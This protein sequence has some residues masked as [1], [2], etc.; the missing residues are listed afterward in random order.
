MHASKSEGG[1]SNV[2]MRLTRALLQSRCT[3]LLLTLLFFLLASPYFQQTERQPLHVVLLTIVCLGGVRALSENRKQVIV[4]L[5]MAAPFVIGATLGLVT[6][7]GAYGPTLFVIPF[8][9]YVTY[10]VLKHVLSREEVTLDTILGAVSG[11]ILIAITFAAVYSF[12]E[13][14]TPGTFYVNV[15]LI[16]TDRLTASEL[17]YFSIV[18]MTTLGYGDIVP[19]SSTA[20]TIASLE[21]LIGVFYLATLIARLVGAYRSLPSSA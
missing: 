2:D 18:T 10:I 5:A 14:L 11:Y 9:L 19:V 17:T 20:R 15:D 21:A 3:A 6:D 16:P 7:T 12:M 4:G 13:Q 8:F 1:L